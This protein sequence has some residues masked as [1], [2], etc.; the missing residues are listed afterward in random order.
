[1][2]GKLMVREEKSKLEKLIP[3][4]KGHNFISKKIQAER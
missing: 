1:M 4:L 3:C 2:S